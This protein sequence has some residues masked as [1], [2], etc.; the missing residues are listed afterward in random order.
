MQSIFQDGGIGIHTRNLKYG[1]LVTGELINVQ[2]GLIKRSRSHFLIFEWNVEVILGINGFVW[3]GKPRKAADQQDLDAIYSS[4]IEP[5][6]EAQRLAI[7]R[8]R[9]CILAM[10]NSFLLIDEETI[11]K[12]YHMSQVWELP[13]ILGVEFKDHIKI[14]LTNSQ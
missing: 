9:N 12:V 1:K 11:R 6:E 3:V 14:S 5:V 7:S 13:S 8:T 4:T 2:P 10:N